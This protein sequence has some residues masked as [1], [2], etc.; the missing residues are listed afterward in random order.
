LK[1]GSIIGEYLD[2]QNPRWWFKTTPLEGCGGMVD[3]LDLGSC[4]VDCG[5]SSPPNP[6]INDACAWDYAYSLTGRATGCGPVEE[7]SSPSKRRA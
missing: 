5:G 4:G 6:I 3:A 7:G 1:K 2:L